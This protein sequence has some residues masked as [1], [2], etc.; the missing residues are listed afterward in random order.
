MQK[1]I[2]KPPKIFKKSRKIYEFFDIMRAHQ[3]KK[4]SLQ[5][6]EFKKLEKR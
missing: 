6:I 2:C 1:S 3:S 5:Q 4:I